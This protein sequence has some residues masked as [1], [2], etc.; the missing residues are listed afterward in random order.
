MIDKLLPEFD[1]DG[2]PTD[3]TLMII[4]EWKFTTRDDGSDPWLA[5]IEFVKGTWNLEYGDIR[6]ELDEGKTLI[7]FITGGWSSNE[8]IQYAMNCN[9]MFRLMRWHSSYRGGTTKYFITR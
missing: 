1:D 5:F 2:D 4:R 9:R 7:C 3:E 8:T 6:E